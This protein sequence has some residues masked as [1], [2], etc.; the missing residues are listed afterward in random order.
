MTV[1]M[2]ENL[3]L[4]VEQPA[5]YKSIL[6]NGVYM[7]F[8]GEG[9]VEDRSFLTAPVPEGVRRG[10]IEIE[11]ALDFIAPDAGAMDP[12]VPY[13]TEIESICLID[14]FGVRG[15]DQQMAYDTQRN[16]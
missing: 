10:L 12:M 7:S 5:M 14:D 3:Q 15:S 2:P 6:L 8:Y 4:A 9:C 1:D 13:G 11:L 16:Q